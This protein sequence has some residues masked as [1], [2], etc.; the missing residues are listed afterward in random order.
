MSKIEYT[1]Q[2]VSVIHEP[3]LMPKK[4]D[5]KKLKSPRPNDLVPGHVHENMKLILRPLNI[6]HEVEFN[7]KE[8]ACIR[9]MT[10]L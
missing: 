8:K 4:I 6:V 2:L 3:M 9:L 1:S 7:E 10:I 5:E